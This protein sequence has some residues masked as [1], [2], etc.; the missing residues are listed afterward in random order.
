MKRLV[1]LLPLVGFLLIDSCKPEDPELDTPNSA[2]RIE[3]SRGLWQS[4]QTRFSF[5]S[6]STNS[7]H[8][9]TYGY[10]LGDNKDSYLEF[11]FAFSEIPNPLEP[12]STDDFN[13]QQVS[14]AVYTYNNGEKSDAILIEN[15]ELKFT[16]ETVVEIDGTYYAT[17]SFLL[18]WSNNGGEQFEGYFRDLKLSVY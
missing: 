18:K 2:L 12:F 17:G 1:Q 7:I 3:S 9:E 6:Y 16:I 11:G 4:T 14:H 5:R 8:L 15:S 13:N 10:Y